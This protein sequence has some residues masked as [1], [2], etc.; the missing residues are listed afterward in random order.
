MATFIDTFSVYIFVN[1]MCFG[2]LTDFIQMWLLLYNYQ[3]MP[4]LHML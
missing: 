3:I 4:T 1:E 2:K